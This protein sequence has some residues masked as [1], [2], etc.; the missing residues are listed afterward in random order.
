MFPSHVQRTRNIICEHRDVFDISED[1]EPSPELV[2]VSSKDHRFKSS[3][4]RVLAPL[5]DS[6]YM[7]HTFLPSNP[8]FLILDK[9]RPGCILYLF[10]WNC[11][12]TWSYAVPGGALIQ[13]VPNFDHKVSAD[14]AFVIL[15]GPAEDASRDY[16]P[17]AKLVDCRSFTL[18]VIYGYSRIYII[19]IVADNI[20]SPYTV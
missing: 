17:T 16:M 8:T 6:L 10:E 9:T 19:K 13:W 7:A 5:C 3:Q 4:L 1:P 20:S 2:T 12:N 11:S 14:G 15:V 18:K